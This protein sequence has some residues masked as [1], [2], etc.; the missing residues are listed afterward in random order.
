MEAIKD[1]KLVFDSETYRLSI[2]PT[3]KELE[4]EGNFTVF[5]KYKP[6]VLASG[7]KHADTEDEA[8]QI[9]DTIMEGLVRV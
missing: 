4:D 5:L 6:N 8:Q 3:P 7:W 1:E 9:A 2:F